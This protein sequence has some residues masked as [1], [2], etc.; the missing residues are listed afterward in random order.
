MSKEV[1]FRVDENG[2]WI[3]T[4]H[5]ANPSGYFMGSLGGEESILHRSIYESVFGPIALGLF[6]R[7]DCDNPSCINPGHLTPGPP[8]AN[9]ADMVERD[10]SIHGES[11]Y[12]SKLTADQVLE[13][14]NCRDED[15]KAVGARYGISQ[16]AVSDIQ[17]GATW[18]HVT[19]AK[20][21]EGRRLTKPGGRR[22][23]T[24]SQILEIHAKSDVPITTLAEMY[25]VNWKT[26][27]RIRLGHS[28]G[29]LTQSKRLDVE[30]IR[31]EVKRKPGV[32]AIYGAFRGEEALDDIEAALK[33]IE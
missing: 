17:R 20:P 12:K 27:R 14:Y 11:H 29:W 6:V 28:W 32:E 1:A 10:R 15:Q 21:G 4:S 16:M 5:C 2:C 33:E 23:L 30:A 8:A 9:S 22:K 3:P 19:G 26:V 25:G 24:E 7:H 13:I 31:D 18:R